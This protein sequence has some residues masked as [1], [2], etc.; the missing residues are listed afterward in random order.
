VNKLKE[1][2]SLLIQLQDNDNKINE[3]T[4]KKNEGPLRIRKLEDELNFIES[5]FQE[6]HDKL[7]SLKKDR[8][9]IEQEIQ[10]LE[11][12]A[13]KSDIKLSGIKSN[14][15]YK[16][17]IKEIDELKKVKFLTEDKAI[18]IMEEIEEL[19]N[20]SQENKN[21]QTELRKQFEK[22][23]DGILEE[24]RNLD[25]ELEI[26]E[27]KRMNFTDAMDQD[28]LKRYHF[29]KERKGGQAISPVVGGVCQT[30]HM[31]IPPQKFN[32]S[33]KG[34]SLLTCPNCNRIIYWG[35]DEHFK[36]ARI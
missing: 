20:R 28:L 9:A 3:I 4:N 27:K 6:E 12:K 22:D 19:E 36:K 16:A 11:N 35:E 13:E 25:E 8:R 10:D 14:K 17:V 18:Q 21:K 33:I 7:E 24:I 34:H 5:K 26:L 1:K 32:E 31:G 29:L 2:I 30:C 15:E 23:K